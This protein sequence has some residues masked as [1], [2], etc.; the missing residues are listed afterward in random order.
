MTF[1]IQK[2]FGAVALTLWSI[3]AFETAVA[4]T[5]EGDSDIVNSVETS[6]QGS[7]SDAVEWSHFSKMSAPQLLGQFAYSILGP[8]TYGGYQPQIL[9]EDPK[10]GSPAKLGETLPLENAFSLFG[11][12]LWALGLAVCFLGLLSL[13]FEKRTSDLNSEEFLNQFRIR[14]LL[15]WIRNISKNWG[16]EKRRHL[17]CYHGALLH[18]RWISRLGLPLR[19]GSA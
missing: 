6:I 11:I 13:S 7:K 16:G 1:Q 9:L 4:V 18:C 15:V 14:N 8:V 2:H 17:V 3:V 12:A 5:I 10:K 19:L